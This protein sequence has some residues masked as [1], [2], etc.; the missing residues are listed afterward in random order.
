MDGDLQHDP[1]FIP[2]LINKYNSS[3]GDIIVGCRNF[4]SKKRLKA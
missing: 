1:K 4:F 3:T 2:K